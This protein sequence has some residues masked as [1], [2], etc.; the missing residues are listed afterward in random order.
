MRQAMPMRIKTSLIATAALAVAL[1]ACGTADNP[2]ATRS[3]K[4]GAEATTTAPTLSP[5]AKASIRAAAGLPPEPAPAAR[6]AFLAALNAIDP[7]IVHGKEDK[8]ISRGLDTCS[9]FKRYPGDTTKQVDM[10]NKRWSSP[11]RP[12][13]HGLATAKKIH[14]AAHTH[15]CPD[16]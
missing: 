15:L 14:A 11:S 9:T 5:D 4:G 3:D 16:F 6:T 2:P 13:G 1:T 8:A 12:D 10:T 7:D